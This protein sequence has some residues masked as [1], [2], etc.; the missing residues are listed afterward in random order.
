[1][2]PEQ[3]N[4]LV[5]HKVRRGR[6]SGHQA[7]K[8]V[9]MYETRHRL[10][11]SCGWLAVH[12]L[13]ADF[14]SVERNL[15]GDFQRI[16]NF[17]LRVCGGRNISVVNLINLYDYIYSSDFSNIEF[18]N[19]DL[20]DIYL[21]QFTL[22]NSR[23]GLS[24]FKC[25]LSKSSFF[26]DGH[27]G[28]IVNALYSPDSQLFVSSCTSGEIKVWHAYTG[29]MYCDFTSSTAVYALSWIDN[30]NIVYGTQNGYCLIHNI[31][32]SKEDIYIRRQ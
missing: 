15:F 10:A 17:R 29:K 31:Q 7:E 5:I 18:C 28:R 25:A 11:F 8:P 23:S 19:L 16:V 4:R 32:T 2:V 30:I 13:H 14:Q 6:Q 22:S 24:F 27:H 20:R 9:F 1:M 3:V 12:A 21:N 26:G